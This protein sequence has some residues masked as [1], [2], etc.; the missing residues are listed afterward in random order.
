MALSCIASEIKQ[1]I[2]RN[3]DFFIPLHSTPPLGVPVGVLPCRLVRKIR[4][5][6]KFDDMFRPF[7]IIETDGRTD[8]E[9]DGHLA[10]V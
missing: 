6:K 2:C 3:C 4:I 7:G 8:G 9:T 10:T 1:D 5:M